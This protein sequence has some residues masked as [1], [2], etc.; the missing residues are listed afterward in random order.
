MLMVSYGLLSKQLVIFG[1]HERKAWLGPHGLSVY[2]S[3]L[4]IQPQ[5]SVF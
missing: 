5:L 4:E 2:S 3:D 1:Q